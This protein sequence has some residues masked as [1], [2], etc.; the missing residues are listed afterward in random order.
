M[1]T[2]SL[3]LKE[4][5]IAVK[6]QLYH[7]FDCSYWIRAEIGE[8]KEN[9]NGH[10]YL[11]L[12][13]KDS[14]DRLIV[15][16]TK[17][18]IWADT[19]RLVKPFFKEETGQDLSA[20]LNILIEVSVNFHEIYGFSC[21]I[22]DIDPTFTVGD[23]ARKR[24]ETINMLKKDGIWEMNKSLPF[25]VP[26]NRIAVISSATAAGYGDF[27]NQLQN[28]K[29]GYKFYLKLFPAIMQGD[30][31]VA[32]IIEALDGVY[33]C[34][35][36]FDIVVIIRGGGATMDMLA[37]DEY[38]LAAHCAQ[39]PLPVITGIGHECD[40]SVVDLIAHTR[41]KTPTAV[42]AFLIDKIN[43]QEHAVNTLEQQILNKV[44]S[45]IT[46][47]KYNLRDIVLS[48][49][50]YSGKLLQKEMYQQKYYTELLKQKTDNYR[51]KQKFLVNKKTD[52][53]HKKADSYL[54]NNYH[55]MEMLGKTFT[56]VSPENILKKGYTLTSKAGKII[57]SANELQKGDEITTMFSDGIKQ[58][59]IK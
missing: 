55:K 10:C 34:E 23:L 29:K 46:N 24:L 50:Q 3:S 49:S 45:R 36:I 37:F 28:N 40:E 57:R 15:A 54:R 59:K 53:L 27:V 47:E 8:I 19:Y 52:F 26:A 12:I 6:Q 18:V 20:G 56:L 2:E 38:D 51:K 48:F 11:E 44:S 31:A 33:E 4:L 1:S 21:V 5:L 30:R 41:C 13:E 25:P 35:G 58:S 7:T 14:S 43:E 39:F 22:R 42:A 32:S 16:K 17:A 9:S